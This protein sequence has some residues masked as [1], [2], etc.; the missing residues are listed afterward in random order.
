MLCSI[1]GVAVRER[2]V[3]PNYRS[4]ITTKIPDPSMDT[5]LLGSVPSVLREFVR[6]DKGFSVMR[7]HADITTK[8]TKFGS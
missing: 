3:C 6:V 5:F 8:Q 1:S 7:G 4:K 2:R